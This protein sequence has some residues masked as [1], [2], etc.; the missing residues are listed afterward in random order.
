MSGSALFDTYA[1]APIAAER[2]E[3]AWLIATDGRRYLDFGSGIAV[4]ALGHAHPAL[5]KALTE[6]AAKVWHTSNAVQ[7]PGQE[8][9]A[10]RLAGS[11]L[12]VRTRVDVDAVPAN[13]ILDAVRLESADL[14]AMTTHGATGLERWVF[15]SVAEKVLRACPVPLLVKRTAAFATAGVAA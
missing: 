9:L 8:R 15:G 7:I 5:I 13:A 1:R 2:G 4:N 12:P 14:V 3:G 11:G 10:Q 6:Q